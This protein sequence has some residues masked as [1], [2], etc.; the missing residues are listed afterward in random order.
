MELTT[1]KYE[2]IRQELRGLWGEKEKGS[3]LRL[4]LGVEINTCTI[5]DC[6]SSPGNEVS[7]SNDVMKIGYI[8]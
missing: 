2:L 6:R 8:K 1:Y 5:S 4:R 7:R 3:W